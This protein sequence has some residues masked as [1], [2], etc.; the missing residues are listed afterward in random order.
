MDDIAK[1]ISYWFGELDS[2]GFALDQNKN[3]WWSGG[4]DIDI[5][6]SHQFGHLV[7]EALNRGLKEWKD[8]SSGRLALILLLDQFTRNIYRGTER[9]FAGD[10][11]A[12]KLCKLGLSE[13]TDLELPIE[14]RVFFY[15]P[16]EHSESLEDQELCI[17]LFTSL[18][19][20]S[21]Q[22]KH[23][24]LDSYVGF[25]EQHRDIIKQFGR[26]PHRNESL[27]RVNT[28]EEETYLNGKAHRFGQ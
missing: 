16:L 5:E 23:P 22:E 18:K 19:R 17:R 11:R 12:L 6:I 24:L 1:V 28:A 20:E 25:A 3:K 4:N 21:P 2:D 9:A 15:M 14:H 27:K 8:S 13:K 10:S 26:F 7:E